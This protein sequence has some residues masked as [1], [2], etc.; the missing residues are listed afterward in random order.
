[1]DCGTVSNLIARLGCHLNN[2]HVDEMVWFGALVFIGLG[3]LVLMIKALI[4][5][6]NVKPTE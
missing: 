6:W 4:E 1:M 2:T 3:G 5:G